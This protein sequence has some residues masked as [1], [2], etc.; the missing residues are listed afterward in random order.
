MCMIAHYTNDRMTDNYENVNHLVLNFYPDGYSIAVKL[1]EFP[2]FTSETIL[3]TAKIPYEETG[4]LDY[5]ANEELPPLLVEM[6]DNSPKL[7]QYKIWRNG[8]LVIEVRDKIGST[9]LEE[10]KN[11]NNN[12]DNQFYKRSQSAAKGSHYAQTNLSQTSHW[13]QNLGGSNYNEHI[14]LHQNG[15]GTELAHESSAQLQDDVKPLKKGNYFV[16]LKPTNLSMLYD[17]LNLTSSKC[18]STQQRLQLESQIVLHNSPSLFLEPEPSRLSSSPEPACDDNNKKSGSHDDQQ[19]QS[20]HWTSSDLAMVSSDDC[21]NKYSRLNNGDSHQRKLSHKTRLKS[22]YLDREIN[23]NHVKMN[24]N[25][26]GNTTGNHHHPKMNN[27]Y[28]NPSNNQRTETP[29]ET[30]PPEL[31]LQQFLASR[32][33]IKK[34]SLPIGQLPR[35]HRYLKGHK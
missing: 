18:W 21:S 30:L 6:I 5:I 32:R 2:V 13:F 29:I 11:S 10:S 24:G 20:C 26:S 19:L 17:V 34:K 4:L 12:N 33:S 25:S 31:T 14:G 7:S 9:I 15:G 27:I 1:N 3:E 23:I 8:C 35:F 16:V 22:I 28:H